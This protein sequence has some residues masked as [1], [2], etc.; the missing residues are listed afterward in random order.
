[1]RLTLGLDQAIEG[2]RD[3]NSDDPELLR[4]RP[5]EGERT[6]E[7]VFPEGTTV[8]NA[9]RMTLDLLPKHMAEGAAPVWIEGDDETLVTLLKNHFGVTKKSRP[10]NWGKKKG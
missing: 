6:T 10:K 7:V 2:Y 1:M 9:F 5:L 4:Y 8:M 3:S